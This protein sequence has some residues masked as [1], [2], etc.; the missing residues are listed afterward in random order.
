MYKRELTYKDYDDHAITKTLLFNLDEVELA[1]LNFD[2][3][4]LAKDNNILLDPNEVETNGV[5]P[6]YLEYVRITN[7]KGRAFG[8]IKE[9]I[10][11]SYG[12]KSPDGQLFVKDRNA[13]DSFRYSA[14]Y[15]KLFMALLNDHN[16]MT[17][18]MN[19]IIP[20]DLRAKAEELSAVDKAKAAANVSALPVPGQI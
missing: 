7:D 2:I 3:E 13:L 17:A 11:R 12:V 14:A 18:F 19:G 10:N 1:E 16:E 5:V 9:I 4:T 15:P 20:Q 8:L 6:A